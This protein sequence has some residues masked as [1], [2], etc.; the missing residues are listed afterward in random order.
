MLGWY[1]GL[2]LKAK[3]YV[4]FGVVI[5]LTLAIAI[6]ALTSMQ[7]S[8]EVADYLQW[9][10]QERY[11]RVDSVLKANI[12]TQEGYVIFFNDY[13]DNK[14]LLPKT[15]NLLSNLDSL[16]DQL[17]MS[18]FPK[19]IGAIKA[20]SARLN[21]IY[22]SKIR[23]LTLEGNVSEAA[24]IYIEEALPNF[25]EIFNN[26][27][28]VRDQQIQEALDQANAAASVTPM[29]VVAVVTIIAILISFVVVGLTAGYCKRAIHILIDNISLLENQ[30]L[31][32]EVE[33]RY[34][35]EF[36]RL[37][38]SLERLRSQQHK[39]ISTMVK[40][41]KDASDSMLAVSED[42][43]R[44]S[45]SAHDAESRSIT[46]AASSDE[47]V[48][49]TKEIANN[50]ESAASLSSESRDIT[51]DGIV[52]AKNS[53]QGI[54]RQSEQTKE[55][56]KQIDAMIS[57]SRNISHI[58]GTID[59]IAS[60]TNL[61]ALNAAIEAAR[62]GEAGRGF[63]VVADEVRALASRTSSSINEITQ[64]VALIESDANA[65]TESMTRSVNDMDA[66]AS[67]TASLENVFNDILNH[68]NDVNSQITHIAAAAEEQ[69][70]ASTEISQHMQNLTAASQE[71]AR[72]ASTT[73]DVINATTADITNLHA[74]LSK[75][76][77]A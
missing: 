59:E 15:D 45:D 22:T 63:A 19:E 23:P 39:I 43:K 13:H 21:E 36:G 17:Q 6:L 66:I 4:S 30:D 56:S 40:V 3:L 70:T 44:L 10:L 76:K 75:F 57:Q 32:N 46:V 31:S 1:Y 52:R 77:L 68:V 55:D 14:S 53:I 27:N 9:A 5:L 38:A 60:Q 2:T 8:R 12:S 42:M 41:S 61:L 16:V 24:N 67:D 62:A 7:K 11:Q 34:Q 28:A 50:C 18:R 71:V 74:K 25:M 73:V 47:M 64:M 35:D 20:G 72:V 29:I 58:V 65:A 54:Y 49:T 37:A 51:A 33:V 69:T 26:I 48:S